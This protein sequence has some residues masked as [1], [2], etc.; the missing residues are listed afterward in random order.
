MTEDEDE[1]LPQGSSLGLC[2]PVLPV[3]R[4]TMDMTQM[5]L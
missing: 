4:M 2:G 3:H 5:L 1:G